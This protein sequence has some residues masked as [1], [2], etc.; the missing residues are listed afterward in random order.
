[1]C[2]VYAQLRHT[3]RN[4]N[5][6]VVNG[7]WQYAWGMFN[8]THKPH[9]AR[10]TLYVYYVLTNVHPAIRSA[11]SHRLI[12]LHGKLNHFFSLDMKIEKQNRLGR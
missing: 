6:N 11:L 1:M 5:V 8:A 12:S 2:L 10:L 3:V 4:N 9:Y 7:T